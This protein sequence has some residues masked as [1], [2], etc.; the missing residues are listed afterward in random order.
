M[1]NRN[2]KKNRK[3]IESYLY[4]VNAKEEENDFNKPIKINRD[5]MDYF[6]DQNKNR[7]KWIF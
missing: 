2:K 4:N 5:N 7:G 6:I 1:K 3:K